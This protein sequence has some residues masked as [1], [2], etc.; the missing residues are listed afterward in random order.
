MRKTEIIIIGGGIAGV[1]TAYYLALA[2][3]Q[4]VLIERRETASAASGLNAGTTWANGWGKT[5]DLETTLGMG[6]LD[7][8]RELQ[9]D[10]GLSIEFRQNGALKLIQTEAEYA[11]CEQKVRELSAAGYD[12]ELLNTR[13]A[14][15]LEPELA[16]VYSARFIC[17]MAAMPIQY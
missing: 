5:P 10:L 11:Y 8:M 15:S 6:S 2:G 3:H 13:E 12:G 17:H 7:I 1:A 4:V 14:R 16:P 9:L